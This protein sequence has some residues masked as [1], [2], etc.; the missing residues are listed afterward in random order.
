MDR[1]ANHKAVATYSTVHT[2]T[3]HVGPEG[4]RGI[5]VLFL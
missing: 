2:R 1:K 4:G 3:D 5:A